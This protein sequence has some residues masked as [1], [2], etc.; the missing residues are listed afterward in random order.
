MGYQHNRSFNK[1]TGAGFIIAM[2]I[3]YGDIGTSPLYTMESIVQGQGGLER[4][5]ETSIIGALSL[6]IWTL[7]LITT[8]KYV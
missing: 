6:I 7:T 4:I 1:A 3:V 5:A 2:G 8:V